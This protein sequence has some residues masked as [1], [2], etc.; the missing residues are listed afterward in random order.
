[1]LTCC[2][3]TPIIDHFHRLKQYEEDF[4]VACTHQETTRA[5]R[6]VVI[7]ANAVVEMTSMVRASHRVP[8]ELGSRPQQL[9]Q[10]IGTLLNENTAAR[11]QMLS[12]KSRWRLRANSSGRQLERSLIGRALYTEHSFEALRALRNRRAMLLFVFQHITCQL[13]R[14]RTAQLVHSSPPPGYFQYSC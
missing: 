8:L 9:P 11:L 6:C 3:G 7:P 2:S 5:N 10:S 1:M 14:F 13:E 4:G 12:A